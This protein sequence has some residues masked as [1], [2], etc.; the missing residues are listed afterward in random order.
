MDLLKESHR[1]WAMHREFRTALRELGSYTD[2]ELTE[3]GPRARR[4]RSD[5]LRGGRAA[6]WYARTSPAG[7]P[8]AIWHGPVP[9]A[10]R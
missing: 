7:V 10:S 6:N 9:A 1:I 2:R 8:P 3:L 5:R 4:H